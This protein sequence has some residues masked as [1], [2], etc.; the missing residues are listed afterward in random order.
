M[1]GGKPFDVE[2]LLRDCVVKK[3]R[4]IHDVVQIYDQQQQQQQQATDLSIGKEKIQ[5][6]EN[7]DCSN[8]STTSSSIS[9][10]RGSI[11]AY[12]QHL[13]NSASTEAAKSFLLS[14]RNFTSSSTTTTIIGGGNHSNVQI[15]KTKRRSRA[16]FSHAQVIEL[17]RRF[18]QQKYLSS[19]ERAELASLLSL[20]EQQVKIWF[21]NRRYKAKRKQLLS[22]VNTTTNTRHAPVTVL[23]Y[24]NHAFSG[25]SSSSSSSRLTHHK[26][27]LMIP[28]I[29]L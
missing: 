14:M 15:K 16:A 18:A 29:N 26:P 19:T 1:I 22:Q 12:R 23:V 25:N 7:G 6:D 9:T 17:E 10:M 8:S 20:Q 5:S 13:F 28:S 3:K 27:P 24:E 11:D 2:S 4:P 21:Q